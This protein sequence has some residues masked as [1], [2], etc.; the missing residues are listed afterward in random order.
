VLAGRRA[1][2]LVAAAVLLL[3]LA[4]TIEG[5]LSASDAAPAYQVRRER[6]VGAAPGVLFRERVGLPQEPGQRGARR[7]GHRSHRH[8]LTL[9]RPRDHHR[10]EA[11]I[12]AGAADSPV[13]LSRAPRM[14]RILRESASICFRLVTVSASY[15]VGAEQE[16]LGFGEDRGQGV[17]QVVPQLPDGVQRLEH[18]QQRAVEVA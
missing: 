18:L 4:G 12:A 17:R 13:H 15:L 2:R 16:Q 14:S 8:D 1:A 6:R 3:C 5:L 11:R 10:G 9:R 7:G